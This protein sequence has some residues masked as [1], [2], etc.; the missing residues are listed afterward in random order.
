MNH[1]YSLLI[2]ALR[3]F[4]DF[5]FGN[6]KG[7]F[8][9]DFF[10]PE[11]DTLFSKY[12]IRTI[13]G[14]GSEISKVLKLLRWCSENVRHNGGTKDVEYISKTSVDILDYAFQKG[15]EYGVYCR[16]Q[17]IVFTECCLALGIKSRILHCLPYNPYDFD[18]HVVS[19]VF[20]TELQKWIML[21]P[22]NNQYFLD[23]FNNILSPMETRK[24]LANE[25][26][27]RCNVQDENYQTYMAKNLFYF[28]SLLHNTF[29]SDLQIDQQTIYCVPKGF[30]VLEREISYCEYAIKNSPDHSVED[31]LK[32]HEEFKKRKTV[33][34]LN[35]SDFFEK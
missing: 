25:E 5:D 30:N 21:D 26:Y 16:L 9:Y 20:I 34:G 7:N 3:V 10:A 35:K 18:S 2:G 24:R 19:M 22:G 1:E 32:A 17:A 15:R 29:G 23:E 6:F 12:K 11:Y 4:D 31:W 33:T 28:K 8:T 13:S 14:D 27:I